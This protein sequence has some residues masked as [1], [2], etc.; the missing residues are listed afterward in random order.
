MKH[1][2]WLNKNG[3]TETCCTSGLCMAKDQDERIRLL[4]KIA[5]D[6]VKEDRIKELEEEGNEDEIKKQEEKKLKKLE[7]YKAQLRDLDDDKLDE[8]LQSLRAEVHE[9]RKKLHPEETDEEKQSKQASVEFIGVD[10]YHSAGVDGDTAVESLITSQNQRHRK[11]KT[12]QSQTYSV[13]TLTD[14]NNS[15]NG[16]EL[17]IKQGSVN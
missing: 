16:D 8:L 4:Q 1:F 7:S 13:L 12:V 17:F 14:T 2:S 10:N 3:T 9:L 5:R 6:H 15:V 11:K